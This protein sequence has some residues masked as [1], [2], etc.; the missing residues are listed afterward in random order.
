MTTYQRAE[1]D[2]DL[3]SDEGIA[4]RY[5]IYRQLRDIPG[6]AWLRKHDLYVLARYDDVR[7]AL[8]NWQTFSQLSRGVLLCSDPPR[9]DALRKVA[10]KPLHP[11]ELRQLEARVMAE[12]DAIVERLVKQGSFDAAKDLASYLPVTVVSKLVGLPQEQRERM[13]PWA[14]AVFNCVGPTNSRTESS[15]PLVQE[16]FTFSMDPQFPGRLDP[17]GWAARLFDAVE[18]GEISH[19]DAVS[20]VNDY[21]APSLDTT[22]LATT[23]AIRLFGENPDQWQLVREDPKLIPHAINEV[24]RLESPIQGFSRYLTQEH[25]VDGVTMPAGARAVVLYA[26]ANRD[27]RK[28]TD[29]ERFDVLRKP[30]GH[31]GFGAGEHRCM[32]LALATL[33]MRAIITALAKR[34]QRFEIG[35]SQPLVNNVL[36]GLR[37]LEVTV[38]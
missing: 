34:V 24:I 16:A 15:I 6:P 31:L 18:S 29:P 2:L 21:W 28:W 30:T 27:E 33:E 23:S 19:D 12:G 5:A 36:H 37:S 7:A 4:N 8:Q 25:A 1:L 32:G 26:S 35:A 20:I 10:S 13:L 3:W 38:H 22:I 11:S 17:G 9:H 14:E